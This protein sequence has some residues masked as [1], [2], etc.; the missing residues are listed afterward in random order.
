MEVQLQSILRPSKDICDVSALY[1]HQYADRIELD[2]YF[3]LFY[4]EK[5]KAY[6]TIERLFLSIRTKGYDSLILYHDRTAV[7]EIALEPEM[8]KSYKV[9]LPYQQ[10][11]DGVFWIAATM[12]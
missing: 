12:G 5:R 8:E 6:T 3:N 9:E 7:E 10:Y 1:Y 11:Q 4:I 2:G